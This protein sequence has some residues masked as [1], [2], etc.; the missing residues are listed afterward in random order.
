[1]S[2]VATRKQARARIEPETALYLFGVLAM[3]LVTMLNEDRPDFR[4]KKFDPIAEG[5]RGRQRPCR[6]HGQRERE[7]KRPSNSGIEKSLTH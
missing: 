5:A 3:T 7:T 2:I 6:R 1:M 4:F